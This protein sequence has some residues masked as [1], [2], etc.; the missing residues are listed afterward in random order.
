MGIN[1]RRQTIRIISSI[2]TPQ[3]R[4]KNLLIVEHDKGV[5]VWDLGILSLDLFVELGLAKLSLCVVLGL[6]E[7]GIS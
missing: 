4:E 6:A 7:L 2:N 3:T 5:E 1:N